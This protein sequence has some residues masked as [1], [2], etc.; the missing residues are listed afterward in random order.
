MNI[1]LVYPW[2]THQGN[3]DG[4]KKG[5]FGK[6]QTVFSL[7][8]KSGNWWGN[9]TLRWALD[10]GIVT[11]HDL[12]TVPVDLL[13]T[14]AQMAQLTVASYNAYYNAP[15]NCDAEKAALEKAQAEAEQAAKDAE[16]AANDA[17]KTNEAADQAAKDAKA[18]QD[19]VDDLQKFFND[20]S[21]IS[22]SDG[23]KITA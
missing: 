18:A 21:W 13:I 11:P 2:D 7:V 5:L 4:L 3:A 14:R 10:N 12:Q 23:D 20:S 22:G 9:D 19:A 16:Q 15:C 6:N 1:P 17:K 8:R